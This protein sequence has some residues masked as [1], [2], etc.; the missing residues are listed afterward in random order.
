MQ[1]TEVKPVT[2]EEANAGSVEL[3]F[4]KVSQE[5]ES[6]LGYLDSEGEFGNAR[7]RKGNWWDEIFF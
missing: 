1:E 6:K 3:S 4:W 2:Y 7:K 5:R